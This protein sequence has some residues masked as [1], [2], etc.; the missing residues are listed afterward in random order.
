MHICHFDS[1]RWHVHWSEVQ[2]GTW[3]C[4]SSQ[5]VSQ[6]LR[7]ISVAVSQSLRFISVAPP[8]LRFAAPAMVV[9]RLPMRGLAAVVLCVLAQLLLQQFSSAFVATEC[10]TRLLFLPSPSSLQGSRRRSSH[11]V[12][13]SSPPRCPRLL[14]HPLPRP[15]SS[16]SSSSSLQ[17]GFSSSS[18]SSSPSSSSVPYK[19]GSP[20]PPRVPRAPTPKS[21]VISLQGVVT[22]SLPNASFYVRLDGAPTPSPGAGAGAGGAGSVLAAVSGRIRKNKVMILVGDVVTVELS[23]YDLTRGRI[24]FRKR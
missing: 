22:S 6:S 5:A 14:L 20:P 24:T 19:K 7:F 3:G 18:P 23:P 11:F 13:V 2:D 10:S 1:R 17:A 16:S 15:S 21:D 4:S 9:L 8:A 12:V